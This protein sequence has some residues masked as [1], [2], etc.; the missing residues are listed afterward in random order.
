MLKAH[1]AEEKLKRPSSRDQPEKHMSSVPV[2]A[3]SSAKIV[4][5]WLSQGETIYAGLVKECQTLESQLEDLETRLAAKQAEVNQ[6]A[7]I[8]GKPLVEGNRRLSA[9]LVTSYA[10]DAQSQSSRNPVPPRIPTRPLR[11]PVGREVVP[12]RP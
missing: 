12:P 9:Q 4:Q 8:I 2:P 6:V 1:Q 5:Q 11:E 10:P 7:Q 3:E